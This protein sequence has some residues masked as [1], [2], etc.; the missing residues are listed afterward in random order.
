MAAVNLSVV[1]K[2]PLHSGAS[3]LKTLASKQMPL[4]TRSSRSLLRPLLCVQTYEDDYP[5][6]DCLSSGV[7]GLETSKLIEDHIVE[8]RPVGNYVFA[9][10]AFIINLYD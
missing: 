4:R 6:S 10:H 8:E 1:L 9:S 3:F 5:E 7:D 2:R